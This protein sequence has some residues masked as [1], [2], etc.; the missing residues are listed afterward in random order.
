MGKVSIVNACMDVYGRVSLGVL[1]CFQAGERRV[2]EDVCMG[3]K[4]IL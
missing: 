4:F 2:D 1:N 3:T